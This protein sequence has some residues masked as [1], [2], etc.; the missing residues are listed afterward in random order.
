MKPD[1]YAVFGDL[2]GMKKTRRNFTWRSP[3][4]AIVLEANEHA[5]VMIYTPDGIGWINSQW[6]KVIE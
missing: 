6:L 3:G 2:P 5:Q 1:E 4:F